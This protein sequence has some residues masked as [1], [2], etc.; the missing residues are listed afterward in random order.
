V[1]SGA[2]A[3]AAER[4]AHKDGQVLSAL[5]RVAV[6]LGAR[7]DRRATVLCRARGYNHQ[8]GSIGAG[9]EALSSAQT[10]GSTAM[11]REERFL[12]ADDIAGAAALG[13]VSPWL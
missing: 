2:L 5:R 12:K 6:D 11:S 1:A 10:P 9:E 4:A 3:S 8:T 7:A 13:S